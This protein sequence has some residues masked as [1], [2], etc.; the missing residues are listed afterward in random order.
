[1]P[2][3]TW[4]TRSRPLAGSLSRAN[5]LRNTPIHASSRKHTLD[6]YQIFT[7]DNDLREQFGALPTLADAGM[8]S[9]MGVPENWRVQE[10]WKAG[11][12]E[13]SVTAG[14]MP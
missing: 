7:P 11:A 6:C 8:L 14:G 13:G 1:M 4:V 5:L 12:S 3:P 10:L 2:S 9:L